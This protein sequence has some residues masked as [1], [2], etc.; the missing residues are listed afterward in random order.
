MIM[1]DHERNMKK[2]S[3]GV[4][5]M[6]YN[7]EHHLKY[8]LPPVLNSDIVDEVLVVNSSGTD[9][10]VSIAKE[11]GADVLIIPRKEFNHGATKEFA[12]KKMRSDIIVMM[13][14]DAYGK[15]GF[16]EAL[17]KPIL[18]E[19]VAL[20]YSRQLPHIGADFFES[21]PREY[22]YPAVSELRNLETLKEK[23]PEAL[24]C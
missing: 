5:F 20:T 17:V 10:T 14:P 3:V 16:I 15:E 13:S 6:T 1:K 19:N 9:K 18:E 22:N 21:F 11:M 8:C 24:F 2:L 12:R 23:G 7:A 4:M